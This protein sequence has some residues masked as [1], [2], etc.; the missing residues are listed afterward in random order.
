MN[1]FISGTSFRSDYGGPAVSVSHLAVTLADAGTRIGLWAPDGSAQTSDVVP[2]AR[3]AL[4]RLAGSLEEALERFGRLDVIHDNGLWLPHNHRIATLA[5]TLL[6]SDV[7]VPMHTIGS[8]GYTYTNAPAAY[9]FTPGATYTFRVYVYNDVH[10]TAGTVAFDD[11]FMTLANNGGVDTDSDGVADHL[12]IDSDNDGITDNVEA[13]TTAGYIASSGIDANADGLDDAYDPGALG[14][15]GGIGITPVNTDGDGTADY[16]DADS[17][18]DGKADITERGDGQPTSLTSTTDTDGDGLLDIFEGSNVNDGFDVNDE[19]RTQSTLNL[20]A[21]PGLNASGSNAIPLTHDLLFR[22]TNIAP[23]VDL[24][25]G[26]SVA[27]TPSTST[28]DL[29]TGGTFGTTAQATPP[30]TWTEGTATTAGA[31]VLATGNGRWDW[32]TA[33]GANATLSQALTVPAA[34]SVTTTTDTSTTVTTTSD[35]ITSIAFGLAWQNQDTNNVNTLTVS[36]GGTVY[37]TFTTVNGTA[38][39]AGLIGTWAYSNGASGPASTNSVTNEATGALTTV[40]ITLP[41]GVTASGNLVFTYGDSTGAGVA[42]DDIAIDNV[43]VTSTKSTTITTTTADIA[44]NDWAATYTENG[45]GVSIADTDSSVF[46]ADS[47]NLTSATITLTNQQTGDQL[48]VNGS[49]DASGTVNGVAYTR[50]AT[51]VVLTGSFTKAEYA[52]AI[53]LITFNNTTDNPNTAV[54]RDITVVANDGTLASNTAHALITVVADVNDAPVATPS[55]SSGGEETNI[56]VDLTGTDADGTIASV[57]VTTLPPAGEGVLYYADGTTPVSTSTPLTPAEAASLVFVPATNFNGDV[58]IAFTVTDD[59]GAVSA[60]ANEVITVTPVNDAPVATP[61]TSSGGEETNI[62]VDLTGTDADG[63]IASV[64]VTTLP[65]VGEG[66]LYYADGTTPVSTSTPLTPAEAASLV[67]IPA[68]NFNGDV[69]IAFTVTDDGGAVSAPANEVVTVTPVNDAPVATPSTSSGGEETNITVDLTGTDADGTIAS[70]TVT[71]LPPA[72]E[73]VLYY[74]DGTT[75]VSTSTPLTPAEAASLVFVPAT[76]FNGDVTIAFTVT[77]DSGAVSAPANE[78]ITVTPVNDAPVATPSTSSGGEE[79]NIT[80]DL[81]GTDA[82]GTIASVTVTTLPPAGE[83]VLYYADGTTP[84]STSTP[85]TPAEAA[86][87]VFVPATNFNGDVTIAFTVTDDSGAVSAPANEVITVTPVND[88]PVATPS[89]SSGGEETNITVDLTG[90]DADGTI[91]SVTVTTLPPVGEGVLYYADG[92]TPVSTSTPLTPA[93]AASLVFIPATNFNGD[94]TIAFT[95]T[96]DGGAVS[97]PANEVITVTPVNDAPVATPSTSSGGE[98]TNITVDLTGT[99][100]DGTIASVTV[101]TLPPAGEGVLYYADGTTPVSTSTP[102]TPAEAASLVFV[103]ATNFNGDVTIAFTVTDDSGAVS[104][105]ANEVVTVTPVNDAPVA[106]DNVYTTAEDTA[107]SGNVITGNTGDGIDSD[108]DSTFVVTQFIVDGTTYAAGTT[109]TIAGVGAL[110]INA[111]GGFTFTPVAN[112]NGAVPTATYTIAEVQNNAVNGNL[113]GVAA[114]VDR[115]SHNDTVPSPWVAIPLGTPDTFNPASPFSGYAWSASPTGGD[116]LHAIGA[117]GTDNEGFTQALTGLVPG[118]SYTLEFS[119]SISNSDFTPNGGTGYFEIVIDGQTFT[120]AVQTTPADGIT[121][122]WQSQ[123]FTFVASSANPTLSIQAIQSTVMRVDLGIDGITLTGPSASALTDTAELNITVTPVNDAPVATP[124]TSS[125]GEE[126]NITVDLTGTDADGTIASVTVTTLPPAG[127][128]VLYYADGT[129]PVSTSTPLTP[130]EAASLVFIPATNFN[131][132]VTIAFTVTDDGGA[133]SAPANEVITVTPVNDAPV[134]TPSTSSGGEETNITVDLTGTDADGTIASVTVTTLPPVGEGVLYYADGTTPVSTS[135]PLTPAEAAS[136]V[137]IP[138]TNFNGDVTI[139]F[140]VTDDSGAVSAPANEVVTVTPVNDAPVATPSTSSGGE[141]TN[142]T[143]DLTGTDID[144]TIASVTVTTLPPATQGVLYFAGGVTP[145]VAGTP[146]PAADAAT[147]VFVPAA[148]FNGTVTIPFTVTDNDGSVST[149]ANEV[150]TVNDVNDPPVDGDETVSLAE[151]TGASGNLLANATDADGDI[152][153]IADFSIDGETGPFTIGSPFLIADVGSITINANGTYS[154]A[155]A[156]NYNGSVPVITYTV[157]DGNGGTDTSTLALTV[158]PVNDAPII[159]LNSAVDIDL[160][161]FHPVATVFNTPTVTAPGDALGVGRTMLFANAGSIGGTSFDIV[162]TVVSNSSVTAPVF[163]STAGT[164]DVRLSSNGAVQV[165]FDVVESGTTTPIAGNFA[166]WVDDLDGVNVKDGLQVDPAYLDAYRLNANTSITVTDPDGVTFRGGTQGPALRPEAALELYLTTASSYEM[167]FLHL[168]NGA[169]TGGRNIQIDGSFVSILTNPVTTIVDANNAVTFTEGDVPVNVADTD[170][171]LFD[172]SENDVVSLE[173]VANSLAD[174]S[175]EQVTIAGH[176]FD[177]SVDDAATG[178]IVGGTS[179]N[180]TYVAATGTFTITNTTGASNPMPEV[181]LDTLIRGITYENTSENPTA[182][183]RTLAFTATDLG[184]LSSNTAVATITVAPVNDPPVATPSTSSGDEDTNIPV[185]LTGTDID[186]TVDFV[187]VTTLP[188]VGEGVLYYADGTTPVSTSTPLTPAEAASLVFIPATNFNGSVTIAFTVTDDDGATSAPA[189]EVITVND[190]NDPPVATPSTSSG[191]EDTNITVDL[192]GT[193]VDGS[194]ASVTVTTLPPVGEGVLYY[195]DGT[196]PVSTSTPLTPAEA[197][198]L[199]F[200][201]A[202]NFNGSVTIA[203]TVTDDDGATSAPA[204][205]VITVNDVN[206]PPVATPSTSSGDEDTNITV[207][208][209][210]TDVDGSIASV[211]VTSLPPVGEGVLYYADGTTPVST[212]TPLT[213]AEA[214]SLVFIPATNFNGDVTIA[215]TVTD[216]SGA[217]SAPANE[218]VTVTPVNDAPVDADESNSVTEDTTLT[219]DA[220]SGLLA[221]TSDVDGGAPSVTSFIVGGTTYTVTPGTPGVATL[222]SGTLTVN[223]DGSYTFAPAANYTG[224]VPVITYT[225]SD[226]AGGT[227]TS[228]LTL[229]MI[230]VNDAPIIDLDSAI[231]PALTTF[232]PA[233]VVF[234]APTITPSGDPIGIGDVLLF[235]NAATVDGVLVDFVATVIANTT[236]VAPSFTTLG[237]ALNVGIFA[238]GGVTLRFQ[239]VE[240]GT[241]NPVSG[242]FSFLESDLDGSVE[243]IVV[244]PADLDSYSL[245]NNTEISV[246][247]GVT[248][249]GGSQGPSYRP[250]TSLELNFANDSTFDITLATIGTDAR[251]FLLSGNFTS[252]LTSPVTTLPNANTNIAFTEG[253]APVAVADTDADL[254]DYSENDVVALEIVAGS[255]TDGAAERVTIGGQTFDLSVDGSASGVAVGGTQIDVAYVAATGRFT[256][257]NATGASN[258]IPQADLDTLIRGITYENT[259]QDPTAGART[260]TFTATDSSALMS[261]AAVATITVVPVNDAPAGVSDTIPV[262]ED[263]PVTQNVLPNDTDVEGSPLTIASAAIDTDG[264]GNPDP[265]VL[266]TPTAITDLGGNPIGPTVAANGD[267]TFD[268][269]PNYTGPIPSLTYTPNDGTADGTPAIV[270]FGPITAVNDAPV[271]VDD[272]IPVTEDTPVTQNVLPNDTDVEGSPLTIASAAIDTD[273]DGIADPLVLGTPTAI[274]DLGGNPI[275]TLTVAANGDVTFDPAPN[276]TGP[277]PSLTYTPNDGTADGTPAIVT[278]GPITPVNDAPVGVDDV[279]PVTEDTPVTQNVLPNDTD[280]EGSSADDRLGGDR[281]RRRRHRRSAGARHA[282]GHH[283]PR[284][285]PDRHSDG[286]RQRRRHVRSGAELHRPDPEP[287]L[288]AERRHGRRHARDRS[289]SAR[290]RRQRRAGGVDD[291][292]PVT[293]TRRSRRTCCRT[294]RMWKATR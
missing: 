49:T 103:P 73:G 188:P 112:Y 272:V 169:T 74:A 128:G 224:A 213:P 110:T 150:I 18:N 96:D 254:F 283:R 205:E 9:E 21:V 152:L 69:T 39:V 151:D 50:T 56:T 257:A 214:A 268:P 139:A 140:T 61:S 91:A 271:G 258:P 127:E 90:T 278:F 105:P 220:T 65:P 33:P 189:N 120:S 108:I 42:H 260:L 100:A 263:T 117:G 88:A 44:N 223:A 229:V 23:I 170:A 149:P 80:V 25:S 269:A 210:G 54:V 228:T 38:N 245:N 126:T 270:T 174:G 98:D 62:T 16:L 240:A 93:E 145:V 104:A 279:I 124:S 222:A 199:V 70:V 15:A 53:E 7:V 92:T 215:F 182:G 212:S 259:A 95:V 265:L 19:N 111:D 192:T 94:V 52:D 209:T 191:D 237:G 168:F 106:T 177:L 138:A 219:V 4:V 20:A 280:V 243:Q 153:S 148:N 22:D 102:L 137:F 41:G 262:T 158:T 157:S 227:D 84:V 60:P 241:S 29:V 208:L 118:Q 113:D 125:G 31:V 83:G 59:G 47:T 87:L 32:T 34:T 85:L 183:A 225:V 143:V 72:G 97:A 284:R 232:A 266:G 185:D 197:A 147:L 132:D 246:A 264:D 162:A 129:T 51:S 109:A 217:V 204:N 43:V 193:D 30:A 135:T 136:L 235:A 211:T 166:F 194:I 293:E 218:V 123:S 289:P 134:A 142:I 184:G 181:D 8:S 251:G 233:P 275:G 273:G 167:S 290:S 116:F 165:R 6:A 253:G 267:V 46:D 226:G 164:L 63:T 216:D 161:T 247:D 230:P 58:T 28:A 101:T 89:T 276:Y 37:A 10:G 75:P 175:A 195:A 27:V 40:T 11:F 200:I 291:V 248:F 207:D 81:T 26:Q 261:N 71:T 48:L 277:I 163:T 286:G 76:N 294:T 178:L 5:A 64:T 133:V 160:T 57:T 287:D 55:T 107:V 285:Q 256:V 234:N 186:G 14:A 24:N 176:A 196:T 159:D 239:V 119:Q 3:G 155:A 250:E 82:D 122:P 45:T 144:G 1:V 203:F 17:D 282:D 180:V 292:I 146:I 202:T 171:D 131:G 115:A 121:A 206:D 172:Y 99:D 141:D 2:T 198:S 67:F 274:T 79:T 13:Q 255:I 190:V 179:V 86:S 252:F 249:L 154:F 12:D 78:V 242:D 231:D 187:T 201:P 35:A 156:A 130:A 36:Y 77:D 288:H 281:H 173:I 66:V 244:D 236:G 114:F 221:N 68:T 238:N